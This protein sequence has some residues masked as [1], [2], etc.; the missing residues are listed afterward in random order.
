MKCL[1]EPALAAR[2][3]AGERHRA[4]AIGVVE[5]DLQRRVAAHRQ[6]DDVRAFDLEMIEHGN[7]VAHH[8]LVGSF[9]I[10]SSRF[11]SSSVRTVRNLITGSV[12]RRRRSTSCTMAPVA[13]ISISTKMPSLNLPTLYARRRLPQTSLLAVPPAEVTEDSSVEISLFRSSSTMSG[14]TININS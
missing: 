14:R 12:T 2:A 9:L 11:N 7:G 1:R 10:L 3:G 4:H 13:S 8:M 5:R 6:A